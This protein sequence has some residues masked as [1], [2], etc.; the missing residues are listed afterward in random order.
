MFQLPAKQCRQ[1]VADLVVEIFASQLNLDRFKYKLCQF[2]LDLE[3]TIL[4]EGPPRIVR[5]SALALPDVDVPALGEAVIAPL[6]SNVSFV[7]K[8]SLVVVGLVGSE[9]SQYWALQ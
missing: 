5:R 7:M 8:R 6:C 1:K 3:A 4:Q 9:S 2:L